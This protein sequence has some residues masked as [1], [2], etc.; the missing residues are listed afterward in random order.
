[1]ALSP[2]DVVCTKCGSKFN[3]VPRQT[4]LGFQKLLCPTC[5]EALTYPLT[6]GYRTTYWVIFGLMALTIILAY[7]QGNIGYPGGFGIAV[8]F[9]LLRDRSIRK[10]I[11]HTP[12]L[13]NQSNEQSD[14]NHK[15]I[16]DSVALQ[17]QVTAGD[18]MMKN[19]GKRAAWMV[20]FVVAF[21]VVKYAKEGYMA[22]N[23]F[24]SAQVNIEKMKADAVAARPDMAPS[25]AFADAAKKKAETDLASSANPDTKLTKAA[26]QFFGFYYVNVITRK[27]YCDKLGVDITPFIT[28]FKAANAKEYRIASETE[29]WKKTNPKWFMSKME[30]SFRSTI[31]QAMLDAAKQNNVSPK[32]VCTSIAENGTEIAAEMTSQKMMPANYAALHGS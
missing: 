4:F 31:D 25:Y 10:R 13:S 27:E 32:E 28:A 9:A 7:S 5:Q 11:A 23:A 14:T 20:A 16:S 21:V 30:P 18:P 12:N 26:D 8:T 19:L 24:E 22:T 1:M 29:S 3:E 2:I 15:L 6:Q 17:S